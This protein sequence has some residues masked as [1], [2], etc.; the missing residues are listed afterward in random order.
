MQSWSWTSIT[1]PPFAFKNDTASSERTRKKKVLIK[2]VNIPVA[3]SRVPESVNTYSKWRE[4][5]KKR[6]GEWITQA[7]T[8]KINAA[9]LDDTSA[10]IWSFWRLLLVRMHDSVC[11]ESRDVEYLQVY[12]PRRQQR[13]LDSQKYSWNTPAST[14]LEP[15]ERLAK[16]PPS[17][18]LSL[19]CAS[20]TH[21]AP[22][23]SRRLNP[24]VRTYDGR[25][26]AA[27]ELRSATLG[28]SLL[29]GKLSRRFC[30]VLFSLSSV[31]SA[32][33]K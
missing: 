18:S 28:A 27:A 8:W 5:R 33:R 10:Q 14:D 21:T 13:H 31:S 26:A 16:S 4:G 22:G 25:A 15:R 29:G 7:I 11:K 20:F 3:G 30:F 24:S 32:P 9:Y 12:E 6:G 19:P 17:L 1:P 23:V 2:G